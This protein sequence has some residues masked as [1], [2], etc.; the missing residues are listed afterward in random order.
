MYM[1]IAQT[2]AKRSTCRRLNVGCVLVSNRSIVSIGYNGAA[3]GEPHCSSDICDYTMPCT[4]TYHAEHNA[5]LR[6]R[7]EFIDK[8]DAYVTDS[9]C[10]DCYKRFLS[11]NSSVTLYFSNPYRMDDHVVS[12]VLPAFRVLPSGELVDWRTKEFIDE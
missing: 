1:D 2:V 3:S 8:I 5:I 6:M 12:G 4:R 9:P 11:L 10:I 7:H